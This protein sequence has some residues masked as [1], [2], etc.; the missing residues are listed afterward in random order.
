[1]AVANCPSCGGPIEF[2]IGSSVVVVCDHCHSIVARTDQGFADL[3]KV[4]ALVDTGSPLRRDLPGRIRGNG[5][6]LVGRTQMRHPMGGVWDEWYAAFDDGQ[7]GWIAEAQGKYYLTVKT[8]RENLPP[9]SVLQI[10]GMFDEM[11]V[12]ELAAATVISG[13]GEIPFRVE[14]GVTY[15]YADLAGANRRFGTIDYSEEPPLL[16]EGEETTLAD[17]GINIALEPGRATTAHVA[18]LSC[19]QC[20]GPLALVAPDQSERVICPHCGAAHDVTSGNLQYLKTLQRHG[21]QP[22]VPLGSNGTIGGEAYVVAGYMQRSVTFDNEKFYWTEYLLFASR[23]K[24][25][26]WLVDDE[27]HWSFVVSLSAGDVEDSQPGDAAKFVIAHQ[28]TFRIFQDAVATVESLIGEFYWKVET[29]EQARAVDYIAPPEG[30]TKEFSDTELSRE[31]TYS[32]ARYMPPEELEAA[33]GIKGLPRP[34]KLGTLQPL[35]PGGPGALGGIWAFLMV[36]FLVVSMILAMALPHRLVLS[37]THPLDEYAAAGDTTTTAASQPDTGTT[38][39]GSPSAGADWSQTSTSGTSQT[40]T[41]TTG[42][43]ASAVIFTKPFIIEGGHNLKVEA[44]A[45]LSEAWL[46]IDG[47]LFNEQ[48]GFVEPFDMQLEHYEGVEDGEHWSEG[49]QSASKTF[50]TLKP[51]TYSLRL[52]TYRDATKPTPTLKVTATEGVFSGTG[53]SFLFIALALITIPAF[54]FGRSKRGGSESER[55]ADAM[56]TPQGELNE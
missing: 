8:T 39:S 53:C 31:V 15:R 49:S 42:S 20:G 35:A 24:S 19:S 36:A 45:D 33:F 12:V 2:K 26:A 14:P 11:K 17:L 56:F 52:E 21:P 32:L 7:W 47:S 29:G 34:T 37:E 25:F 23:T 13:E 40:T 5:F 30:I 9:Y 43:E 6:R 28:V 22:V 51:G 18:K 10:G 54:L 55:W 44:S 38:T 50:S 3:G 27:D 4:A 46:H 1:M 48:S 16:F 41:T